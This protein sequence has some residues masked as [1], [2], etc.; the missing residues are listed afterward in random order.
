[1]AAGWCFPAAAKANPIAEM[2]QIVFM[3][4]ARDLRVAVV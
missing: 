1:M 4:Y 3:G 2:S